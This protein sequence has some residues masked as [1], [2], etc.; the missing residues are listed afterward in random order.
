MLLFQL[1]SLSLPKPVSSLMA[2]Q[3]FTPTPTGLQSATPP[4]QH[5]S[6]PGNVM[7]SGPAGLPGQEV[8]Y[9]KIRINH[10]LPL[11]QKRPELTCCVQT[12]IESATSGRLGKEVVVRSI[13][14]TLVTAENI[15]KKDFSLDPEESRMRM[16]AQY[17]VRHIAAAAVLIYARDQLSTEIKNNLVQNFTAN[18]PKQ[19]LTQQVYQEVEEAAN[20]VTADN[21]EAA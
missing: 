14:M 12:A 13:T 21:L 8:D 18:I 4:Q 10:Q 6:L 1:V 11:F 19:I 9:T 16:A 2:P 15:I 7:H 20:C 3:S 17:M 5:P